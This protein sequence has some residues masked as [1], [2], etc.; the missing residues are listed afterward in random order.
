MFTGIYIVADTVAKFY[1]VSTLIGA[2]SSIG[3]KTCRYNQT[4][5]IIHLIAGCNSYNHLS[6]C[7]VKD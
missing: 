1:A 5:I 4:G 7:T 2:S 3:G 6:H